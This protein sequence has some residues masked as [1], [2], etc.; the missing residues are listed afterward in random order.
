MKIQS[1]PLMSRIQAERIAHM[2]KY[3]CM[4]FSN[5]EIKAEW[6]LICY[7]I[8]IFLQRGWHKSPWDGSSGSTNCVNITFTHSPFSNEISCD[9]V[10]FTE[11]Y[12]LPKWGWMFQFLLFR[13]FRRNHLKCSY[14]SGNVR[15]KLAA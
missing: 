12:L 10:K 7:F 14:M 15:Q 1:A 6:F 8:F 13:I 3:S 11:K 4:V 9:A 2:Q 5:G